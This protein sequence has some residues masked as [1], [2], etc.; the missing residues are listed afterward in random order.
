MNRIDTP[1]EP[2]DD[3]RRLLADPDKHWKTGFSAH[4]LAHAWEDTD[5]F[6]STV[7]FGLGQTFPA[8][9]PLIV[10]PEHWVALPGGKAASQNAVWVLAKSGGEFISITI[11]GKV[12]ESSGPTLREWNPDTSTVR[13]K[14]FAFLQRLLELDDIPPVEPAITR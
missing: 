4:S 14:R 10:L 11:L 8:I 6:P 9:E 1:A 3:W 13:Q 5:G 2:V 12:S 7:K